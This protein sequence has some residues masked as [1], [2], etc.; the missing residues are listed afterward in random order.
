MGKRLNLFWNKEKN[1][2]RLASANC[3]AISEYNE[4]ML[5]QLTLIGGFLMMLPLLAAPFSKTKTDIIPA[6]LLLTIAY[7][8]LFFIFQLSFMKKYTLVGLYISFSFLFSFAIY[9]SVIHS[10]NMRATILLGA[11]CIIP[12]GFIDHP[13]RMNLF[14]AFWLGLHTVLAFYL[15]PQYALDDTINS[16]CFAILG[17]FIGNIMIWV[18]LE[19]HEVHRLLTIEKE[20]DVL[21]GLFNR[22]KLFETLAVLETTN[23]EKPTGIL[24]IDIDHFKDFNDHHGHAVGDKCL[25]RLGEVFTLFTQ[26]F[27]LHFYRYGGEEFV[28]MA[29]GYKEE[30]L[31]AIAESLRI[32]VQITDMDGYRATV[33]IGVAYCGD[34][35]VR[36]YENIIDRADRAAYAA[37]RAGRNKVC[38][39]QGEMQVKSIS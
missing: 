11:F 30:E 38:M 6:Y 18:R 36:N 27:R 14:A 2:M 39:E 35:Q 20:T 13:A 15:K 12:L 21:T 22:R 16:L 7:F 28:A 24:M 4:K 29:Y 3:K 25:S 31:L 1:Y 9:L 34:E 32:A 5:S 37:K 33:S 19:S 17:C 8:S 23:A 10:P 26:S